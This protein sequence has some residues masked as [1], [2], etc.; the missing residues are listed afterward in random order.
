MFATVLDLSDYVILFLIVSLASASAR[1][2]ADAVGTSFQKQLKVV[3]DKLNRIL[4]YVELLEQDSPE[5]REIQQKLRGEQ[6][7][8]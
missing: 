1:S 7:A 3:E 4:S 5:Y 6:E 8:K 2:I